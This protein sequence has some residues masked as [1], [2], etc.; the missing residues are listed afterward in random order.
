MANFWPKQWVNPFG[1]ISISWSPKVRRFLKGLTQDF[2]QKFELFYC[3]FLWKRGLKI[4]FDDVV[5]TNQAF[6]DV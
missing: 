5:A 2:G 6:L 1:K 4:S 3:F